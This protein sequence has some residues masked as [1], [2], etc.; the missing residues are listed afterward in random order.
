M[1]NTDKFMAL[2]DK[3]LVNKEEIRGGNPPI[4]KPKRPT[5]GLRPPFGRK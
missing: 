3:K 2:S 5:G 1:K 4:D